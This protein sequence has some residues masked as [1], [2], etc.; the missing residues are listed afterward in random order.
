MRHKVRELAC[1]RKVVAI[2]VVFA[3]ASLA[4]TVGLD[5]DKSVIEGHDI[6]RVVVIHLDTTR[7]DDLG[8]YGGIPHTPNIDAVA[9]RGTRFTNSI[10]PTPRTSPSIASF[11][12]GRLPN[13]HGV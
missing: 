13:R 9:A 10:A 2:C 4:A 8:C 12:T 5:N 11:M 6:R 1:T 3:V 7:V